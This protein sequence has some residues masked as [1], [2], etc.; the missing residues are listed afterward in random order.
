MFDVQDQYSLNL[1]FLDEFCK[2]GALCTLPHSLF[3]SNYLSIYLSIYRSIYLSISR[4][5]D[6]SVCLCLALSFF[7]F[8]TN[9]N[10]HFKC[11]LPL[12]SSIFHLNSLSHCSQF[13]HLFYIIS[14]YLLR[15]GNQGRGNDSKQTI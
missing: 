13:F 12:T 8:I 14:S 3:R 4:S 1:H 7:L 5:L 2:I 15:D 9:L 11:F 10:L 6:L